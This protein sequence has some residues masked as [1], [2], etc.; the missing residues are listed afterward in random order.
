MRSASFVL[1]LFSLLPSATVAQTSP[2]RDPATS[3]VTT[4]VGLGNSF[5]G[6]GLLA[7]I[8][9][10]GDGPVSLVLAVGSTEAAVFN[11]RG[12]PNPWTDQS[13]AKFAGAVGVRGQLGRGGHQPFLELALLP[14][15]DD[16]VG[17]IDSGR[18]RLQLLYGLGLQLGYRGRLADGI[19]VNVMAGP[20]YALSKDVIASRWKPIWGFGIGYAWPGR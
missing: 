14:V 16:V 4:L 9:A 13:V 6:L 19:T 5:G 1:L 17:L 10:F 20:G 2:G 8:K 12:L 3:R 7:D 11:E 15:D 18:Q